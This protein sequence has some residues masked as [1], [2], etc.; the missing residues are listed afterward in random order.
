MTMWNVA[1][2]TPLS[3][4]ISRQG[5]WSGL[6][7]PP[8]WDLPDQGIEPVFLMSLALAGRFFTTSM[9]WEAFFFFFCLN[10]KDLSSCEDN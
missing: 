5:Y 3:M 7:C 6:P 1:H 4:G 2:Q 10:D 9:T 8:P